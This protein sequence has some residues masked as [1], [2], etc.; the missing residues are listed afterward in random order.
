MT[1]TNV[2][3]LLLFLIK[4]GVVFVIVVVFGGVDV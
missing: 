2:P 3:T 4:N 1:T